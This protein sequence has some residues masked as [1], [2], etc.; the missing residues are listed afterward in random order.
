M[1]SADQGVFPMDTAFKRR[2]NFEYLGINEN[3]EKISGIGK[4]ELAGSEQV[5]IQH[6][7]VLLQVTKSTLSP[8]ADWAFFFGW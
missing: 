4:I 3:E 2:W 7:M 5:V 6:L 1:N 8:Y